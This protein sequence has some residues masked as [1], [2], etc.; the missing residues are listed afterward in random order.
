MS[1]RYSGYRYPKAII[2]YIVFLY[3]RF[4]LS[5]RDIQEL[6]LERGIAV[7]YET[8]RAWNHQFGR[9]LA[10]GIQ[11]RRGFKKADTIHMDEMRVKIKGE[12]F[13]L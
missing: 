2:G 5:L 1:D 13:W 6:L 10:K 4:K 9:L 8:I 12:V 3:H 7:T 11:R